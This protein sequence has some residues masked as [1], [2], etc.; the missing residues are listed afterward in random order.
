MKFGIK[1]C[2]T[3][4]ES[5]FF[6]LSLQHYAYNWVLYNP[7]VTFILSRQEGRNVEVTNG[8]NPYRGNNDISYI[9]CNF[10]HFI[11]LRMAIRLYK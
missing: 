8:I 11:G 2:K 6:G 9:N 4:G 7:Y 10:I 5:I 1:V 3:T